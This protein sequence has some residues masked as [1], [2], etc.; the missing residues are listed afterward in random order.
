MARDPKIASFSRNLVPEYCHGWESNTVYTAPPMFDKAV[1][2][3]SQSSLPRLPLHFDA[4]VIIPTFST[5]NIYIGLY[6]SN[7]LL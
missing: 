6:L 4:E 1:S 2:S 7:P 5:F 3:R